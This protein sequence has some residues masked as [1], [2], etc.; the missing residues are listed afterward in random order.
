MPA[1]EHAVLIYA[2]RHRT[3]GSLQNKDNPHL[4]TGENV[5]A[6]CALSKERAIKDVIYV[7]PE[8]PHLTCTGTLFRYH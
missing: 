4:P 1:L 6:C 7:K 8:S 5:Q 3:S 2:Q